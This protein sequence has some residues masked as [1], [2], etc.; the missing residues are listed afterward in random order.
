M[1]SDAVRPKG[2]V[3]QTSLEI[4]VDDMAGLAAAQQDEVSR[5]ELCAAL[6]LG[7]ISPSAGF[8]A[9]A[10][11][12]CVPVFVMIR[13]RAGNFVFSSAEVAQMEDDITLA[14]EAGMDGVVLGASLTDGTLDCVLLERLS[15]ACGTMHRQLHRVFDLTPDPVAALDMAMD[16][17]FERVLTS[18]QAIRA[19]EGAEC[20]RRLHD[21]A[22]GRIDI[23]A[24]G[25][26]RPE[27]VGRL[28]EVSG[29]KSF[30]A[31]CRIKS[32]VQ[33]GRLD[34]FGFAASHAVTSSAEILRLHEAIRTACPE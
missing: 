9:Q 15:L 30:H 25:H 4:C 5:I 18:G 31:S 23:M 17:G 33:D 1:A 29:V 26:V 24:G 8:V 20:L 14:R 16:L 32:A 6:D 11:R 34:H 22:R 3:R 2:R 27:N 10:R 12:S 13:P 21:H 28:I 19:P 7:G